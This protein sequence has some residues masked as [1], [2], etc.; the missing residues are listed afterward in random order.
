MTGVTFP[1]GL[2]EGLIETLASEKIFVSIRGES[3]RIAPHLY[4]GDA[5]IDRLFKVLFRL[6]KNPW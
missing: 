5:D 2:P 1:N 4:T 3:I 6:I